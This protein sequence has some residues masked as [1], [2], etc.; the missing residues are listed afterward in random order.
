MSKLVIA[1]P[2]EWMNRLRKYKLTVDGSEAG[3]LSRSEI[4]EFDLAPGKHQV[5]AS[6]GWLSSESYEF[7]LAENETKYLKVTVSKMSGWWRQMGS[8]VI[9]LYILVLRRIFDTRETVWETIFYCLLIIFCLLL[10]YDVTLGRKR[11]LWIRPDGK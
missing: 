6:M 4:K 9:I 2:N 5:T 1:R 10:I 3:A 11:H 7:E 8:V